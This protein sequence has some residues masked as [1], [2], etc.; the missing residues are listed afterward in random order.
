MQGRR[1][2]QVKNNIRNPQLHQAI[3]GGGWIKTEGVHFGPVNIF[4][5]C[6][7]KPTAQATSQ[8]DKA[9]QKDILFGTE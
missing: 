6:G 2:W 4:A 1:F 5:V 9:F 3:L 8:K 7:I